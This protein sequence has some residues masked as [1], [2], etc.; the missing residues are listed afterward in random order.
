MT[1][2]LPPEGSVLELPDGR[3]R[4]IIVRPAEPAA[5]ELRGWYLDRDRITEE[6]VTVALDAVTVLQDG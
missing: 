6:R 2:D 3:F 1:A 4:A 5:A